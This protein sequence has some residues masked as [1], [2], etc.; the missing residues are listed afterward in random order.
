MITNGNLAEQ[1]VDHPDREAAR[2]LLAELLAD[3]AAA[4]AADAKVAAIVSETAKEPAQKQ[5][6]LNT[7]THRLGTLLGTDD[8]TPGTYRKVGPSLRFVK[9]K[10]DMNF[11]SNWIRNPLDFR[12]T[13][14][15][16]KF[17]GSTVIYAKSAA[18]SMVARRWSQARRRWQGRAGW[19]RRTGPGS[20]LRREPWL[21]EVREIRAGRDSRRERV[22]VGC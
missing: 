10:L 2:K 9:S 19:G 16:P 12:P 7:Q 13:T 3:D 20:G 18:T 17:F 4:K 22:P 21:G 5:A 6:R 8:E 14:R 11:L 15:M 1:V